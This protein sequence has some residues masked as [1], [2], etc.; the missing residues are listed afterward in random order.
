MKGM[1][2]HALSICP[3]SPPAC[4]AAKPDKG[5][6]VAPRL[7]P[8]VLSAMV[9]DYET[10]TETRQRQH[11]ASNGDPSRVAFVLEAKQDE[12]VCDLANALEIHQRRD[13][14]ACAACRL[15]R[16]LGIVVDVWC[17]PRQC[18]S[19]FERQAKAGIFLAW[20]EYSMQTEAH[21]AEARDV[22][23]D[24]RV[25]ASGLHCWRF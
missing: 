22:G 9:P 6:P 23:C 19:S 10:I 3:E 11:A 1:E 16:L 7:V 24:G 17:R 20:T 14:A 25:G 13:L 15:E 5:E 4:P 12:A 8:L 2:G 18:L 21:A